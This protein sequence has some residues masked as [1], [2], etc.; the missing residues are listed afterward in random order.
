M[1]LDVKNEVMACGSNSHGQLGFLKPKHPELGGAAATGAPVTRSPQDGLTYVDTPTAVLSL[2][3]FSVKH[4][5]TSHH[6]T[7]CLTGM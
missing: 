2:K 5:S 6:H 7:I 3:V 1:F 4:I